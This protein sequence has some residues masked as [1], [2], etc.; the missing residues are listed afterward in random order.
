MSTDMVSVK[1]RVV[2]VAREIEKENVPVKIDS[3][4]ATDRTVAKLSQLDVYPDPNK[5]HHDHWCSIELY[6]SSWSEKIIVGGID[7]LRKEGIT[8]DVEKTS[9]QFVW[10]IDW[11][12]KSSK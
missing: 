12:L 2:E 9:N 8:F 7:K 6:N 1:D 5:L 3:I 11:S 10:L 4:S